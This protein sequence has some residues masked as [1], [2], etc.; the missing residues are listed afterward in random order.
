MC[1]CLCVSVCVC[2]CLCV[3]VC[4]CV[5]CVCLCVSFYQIKTHLSAD[6]L[7]NGIPAKRIASEADKA[8]ILYNRNDK[9]VDISPQKLKEPS[10]VRNLEKEFTVAFGNKRKRKTSIDSQRWLCKMCTFANENDRNHCAMCDYKKP[11]QVNLLE[12][13]VN[14]EEEERNDNKDSNE[15]SD[16]SLLKEK[17]K[18]ISNLTKHNDQSPTLGSKLLDVVTSKESNQELHQQLQPQLQEG[19]EEYP[20]ELFDSSDESASP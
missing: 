6:T 20:D 7:I 3:S 17:Q 1:V 4:V 2:V 11:V 13:D 5:C 12:V 14:L 15:N 19:V 8:Y 9:P 10:H 16:K 18:N